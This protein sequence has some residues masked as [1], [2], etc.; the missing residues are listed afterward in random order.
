MSPADEERPAEAPAPYG[1]DDE[2]GAGHPRF[3]TSLAPVEQQVGVH[4]IRALQAPETVAVLSTVTMGP[5]GHQRIISVGLDD[6]LLE[7]VR[8]LLA[9]ASEERTERVPCVGF[10]CRLEDR[11]IESDPG[12]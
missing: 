3:V 5:D 9:E 4:V 2:E 7:Q 10:H 1:K 8:G 12:G 6:A 11:D